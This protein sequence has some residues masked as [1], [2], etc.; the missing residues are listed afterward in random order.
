M[1]LTH[2]A[3]TAAMVNNVETMWVSAG[4]YA[5]SML[6]VAAALSNLYIFTRA[7]T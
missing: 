4:D 6:S 5:S 2:T 3:V 1:F 7:S